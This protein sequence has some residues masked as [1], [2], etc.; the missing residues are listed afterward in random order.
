MWT[1]RPA[2]PEE[3]VEACSVIRQSI[4]ELCGADHD[5]DPAILGPWLVN[6][7]PERVR[8]WIESNPAGV[9]VGVSPD[10]IAG[11][12]AVLRDGRI[13]LNYV[14]PWA[15]F[16]GV[17]KGLL[18]AMENR[19]AEL[20]NTSCTLTSTVTAHGF[21]RSRGYEDVGE[22]VTSFGGKP[23]FPMRRAIR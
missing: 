10:E 17:S 23:A 5:G 16:R 15:R 11:M 21:Y 18:R 6:K 4:E 9:L 19:A 22:P 14:A 12:G 13:V 7:T 3:A 2:R 1:F 20:G 8:T